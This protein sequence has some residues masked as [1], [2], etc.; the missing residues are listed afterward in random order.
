[1][2]SDFLIDLA[3]MA[4]GA[5]IGVVVDRVVGDAW[6]K[7]GLPVAGLGPVQIDDVLLM[8]TEGLGAYWMDKKGMKEL[9]NV[10]IGMFG[11]TVAM[12]VYEGL[13][14][15]GLIVPYGVAA[16]AVARAYVAPSPVRRDH[17]RYVVTA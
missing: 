1:M 5:A 3:T 10:L 2:V 16:P 13:V 7:A 9:R 6:A 17:V 15:A 4:G 11:A 12:E 14:D 8:F